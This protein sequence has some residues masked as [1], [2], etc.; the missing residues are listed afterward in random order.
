MGKQ[1]KS[2]IDQLFDEDTLVLIEGLARDGYTNQD[3]AH[4]LGIEPSVLYNAKR[5]RPEINAAIN[6]GKQVVDY[7]VENA[8]LKSALGYKTKE[9][10]ITTLM[11][12][13]KVVEEQKET[14]EKE[15]PPNSISC[16]VWLYNRCPDKW[17]RNRDKLLED[18]EEATIQVTVKRATDDSEEENEN[19]SDVNK[20]VTV[21]NKK[22]SKD[23]NKKEVQ[24][25]DYWPEDW[26]DEEDEE[27]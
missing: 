3:I 11:R 14:L 9:T 27:W 7:K 16:Q 1:R 5:E 23:D 6:R 4:R 26:E 21:K 13:G 24:D 19:W 25:K 8:L 22:Q 2:R 10:K 15:V 17:K 18:E 12:Y 20:S